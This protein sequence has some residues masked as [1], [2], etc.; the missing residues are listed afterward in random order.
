MRVPNHF[1]VFTIDIVHIFQKKF[2]PLRGSLRYYS[3]RKP[4]FRQI[5]TF[6]VEIIKD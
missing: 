4:H 5:V 2:F 1:R 6:P 3:G